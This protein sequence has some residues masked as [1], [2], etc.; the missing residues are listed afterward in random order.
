M[1]LGV[2]ALADDG[3]GLRRARIR[4]L[5]G[6]QDVVEHERLRPVACRQPVGV[7]PGLAGLVQISA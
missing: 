6:Q 3:V 4:D 1:F 7:L 2:Q 5:P